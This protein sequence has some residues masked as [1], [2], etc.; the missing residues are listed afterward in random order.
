MRFLSL[1]S[2]NNHKNKAIDFAI[3]RPFDIQWTFDCELIFFRKCFTNNNQTL[4]STIWK[5]IYIYMWLYVWILLFCV[6]NFI[7]F[8]FLFCFRSRYVLLLV[9]GFLSDCFVYG[10][11][12]SCV[13]ILVVLLSPFA[14]IQ[15]PSFFFLF[16][17]EN[18]FLTE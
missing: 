5:Y 16:Y 6:T 4:D 7:V 8:S 15:L 1:H 17:P 2:L 18:V 10:T 11:F 13:A 14:H 9:A 12:W 3:G